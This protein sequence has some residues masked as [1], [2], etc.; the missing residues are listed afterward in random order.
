MTLTV[1]S[2]RIPS[3]CSLHLFPGWLLVLRSGVPPPENIDTSHP[4][5]FNWLPLLATCPHTATLAGHTH[6]P[7]SRTELSNSRF[8]LQCVQQG[9]GLSST[10]ECSPTQWLAVWAWLWNC[11][12]YLVDRWF[13]CLIPPAKRFLYLAAPVK[14]SLYLTIML[15]GC[16]LL[17]LTCL[18]STEN[19]DGWVFFLWVL[20]WITDFQNEG[21]LRIH[22]GGPRSLCL[23]NTWYRAALDDTFHVW[24]LWLLIILCEHLRAA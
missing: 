6:W 9:K 22:V 17:L 11:T 2:G 21:Y 3:L 19:L 18:V 16:T 7:S 5:N 1:S 4:Y 20:S 24:N 13:L 12:P 14:W 8:P 10:Q 23:I 15:K